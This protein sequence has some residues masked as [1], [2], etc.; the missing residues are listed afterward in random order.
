MKIGMKKFAIHLPQFHEIEENNIWW[1]KG[2]T[3]W[4]NVKNAKSLYKGHLEGYFPLNN[5]YYDLMKKSTMEWQKHLEN[6]YDIDGFIYYHY[7]FNG[8]SIMEKP[9]EN[10]LRWR[11]IKQKY[12]FCW[13][14][15]SWVK[16]V[17]GKK[18]IL[19]KQEYGVTK[20]W[21]KHFVYLLSF[22]KDERYEKK[23]NKPL[24]MI[25]KPNFDEYE[26][27]MNYF[28][29]RC[30]E[31]G[32]DGI[33]IIKTCQWPNE[34]ENPLADNRSEMFY[35]REPEY[36]YRAWRQKYEKTIHYPV[37]I[38]KH[39][40]NQK[41]HLGCPVYRY[42][43]DEIYD[44]MLKIK[45]DYKKIIPGIF[46]S[47]DSTVRHGKRGYIIE[48]CSKDKFFEYMDYICDSEYVF[49]NA[50]NEWSEGMI[51]EPTERNGYKYLEWIKEWTE[52]NAKET[53]KME[54]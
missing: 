29:R 37:E 23:H 39:K 4:T 41:L 6:Q 49:I 43:G 40:L 13:A 33:Y 11:D 48:E 1:G 2:F 51:L 31:E 46:F 14:N 22:F 27:M 53:E 21:E 30:K 20:D 7:Y 54:T 19:I 38:I 12:F 10:L 24:F 26:D 36:S 15:H 18:T 47:W 28:N 32:F 35:L 17:D 42:S 5:N 45:R 16:S 34:S 9:L 44:Y 8:K 3:E 52:K 50:W 25:F